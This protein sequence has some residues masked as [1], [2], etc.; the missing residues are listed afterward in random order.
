MTESITADKLNDLRARVLSHEAA[1][2]AGT[3]NPADP[4]YTL[5]ELKDA[6]A[7]ISLNRESIATEASKSKKRTPAVAIDL[8]DML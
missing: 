5:D 3:A 8:S 2:K 1:V 7:A 6:L 4:P